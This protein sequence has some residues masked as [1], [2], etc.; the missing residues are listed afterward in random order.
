M[1]EWVNAEGRLPNEEIEVI[2][3]IAPHGIVKSGNAENAVVYGGKWYDRAGRTC[4]VT[5][6]MP[7]PEPPKV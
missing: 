5:H 3:W 6:W 4:T 1:S 7:L 2:A